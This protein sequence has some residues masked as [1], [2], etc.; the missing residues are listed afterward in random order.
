M[1]DHVSRGIRDAKAGQAESSNR[2]SLTFCQEHA[3]PLTAGEVYSLLL[4]LL[5]FPIGYL[6]GRRAERR[7]TGARAAKAR[8][9]EARAAQVRAQAD[10]AQAEAER[11][12]QEAAVRA[13]AERR[14]TERRAVADQLR[15][16]AQQPVTP[17]PKGHG[18]HDSRCPG[19]GHHGCH[20]LDCTQGGISL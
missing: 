17:T 13:E 18:C 6:L 5:L 10:Q 19:R 8:L 7:R 12:R 16:L 1:T 4:L 9:A 3:A 11:L 15:K 2:G 14:T 20:N